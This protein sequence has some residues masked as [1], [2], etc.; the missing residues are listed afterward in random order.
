[1]HPN[2]LV[3]DRLY[4]SLNR[5]EYEAM[6]ACYHPAARFRDIAFDLKGRTEIAVMWRMICSG[7]IRA[8]FEV[9]AADN[10][11]VTAMLT[12]KY[13][14]RGRPVTNRIESR[15]RF[16]DGL[17]VE[18]IDSC[19]ARAWP[20][21]RSAGSA[22]SCL[23]GYDF[24]ARGQ[25]GQDCASSLN[26]SARKKNRRRKY[27]NS[28][29]AGRRCRVRPGC[30]GASLGKAFDGAG[31]RPAGGMRMN[32]GGRPT[33]QSAA[34]GHGDCQRLRRRVCAGSREQK[35]RGGSSKRFY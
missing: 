33:S 4:R 12:D 2:A 14:F 31:P 5:H 11:S 20:P 26:R 9:I 1:M 17:I 3:I 30:F 27:E 29:I 16:A 19:D 23:A 21:R 24:C 25:R 18:H 8:S 10:W 6:A 34:A 13:T 32:Q 22:D 28:I 35:V 15:F 7:D